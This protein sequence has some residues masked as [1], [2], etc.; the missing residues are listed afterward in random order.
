MTE[1]KIVL[2]LLAMI[3]VSALLANDD[4][5]KGPP[6]SAKACPANMDYSRLNQ[7]RPVQGRPFKRSVQYGDVRNP[8]TCVEDQIR[9]IDDDGCYQYCKLAT[10]CGGT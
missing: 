5:Y 3:P 1:T 7:P 2:L 10:R 9:W 4:C 6:S 8:I